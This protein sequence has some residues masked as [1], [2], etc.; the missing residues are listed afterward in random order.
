MAFGCYGFLPELRRKAMRMELGWDKG[1]VAIEVVYLG[2]CCVYGGEVE[3]DL[4]KKGSKQMTTAF[5][6][7][8]EGTPVVEMKIRIFKF[9]NNAHGRLSAFTV[10]TQYSII[11]RHSTDEKA[12]SR[13]T[14]RY[15]LDILVLP[16]CC[17]SATHHRGLQP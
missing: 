10:V 14:C 17:T 2:K 12:G 5:G 9:T 4:S 1:T 11:S 15:L 7:W 3:G 13:C 6:E 8:G 16:F